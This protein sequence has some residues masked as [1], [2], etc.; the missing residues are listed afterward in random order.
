MLTAQRKAASKNQTQQPCIFLHRCWICLSLFE[1]C[2]AQYSEQLLPSFEEPSLC[3]CATPWCWCWRC[4]PPHTWRR[5]PRDCSQSCTLEKVEKLVNLLQLTATV[6]ALGEIPGKVDPKVLVA[7]DHFSCCSSNIKEGVGASVLREVHHYLLGLLHTQSMP[8]S[9][10][11]LDSDSL[12]VRCPS[13]AASAANV[14][15]WQ[16][17][18][19]S[20]Q[21]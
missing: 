15:I 19:F 18:D 5:Y 4:S 3:C 6:P 20:E 7:G 1:G 21:S 17:G 10:T 11:H 14:T 12:V 9:S 8:L 16:L 2:S 13:T